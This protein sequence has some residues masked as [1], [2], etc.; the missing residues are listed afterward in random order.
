VERR[1]RPKPA[2]YLFHPLA[3][4]RAST[5]VPAAKLIVLLRDPITRAYSHWRRE[6]RDGNEP[7]R[8]FEEAIAAEAGRL[9]GEVERIV[10][11][12]RYYSYAHENFSY[13]TLGLYLD[14]LQRWFARY[15]RER[16]CIQ[17]TEQFLE[18][19]QAVYGTILRFLGLPPHAAATTA[20]E[21]HAYRST[22]QSADATDLILMRC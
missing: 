15:P 14:G 10:G 5:V 17:T 16:V 22:A 4:E 18:D 2:R 13:I 19:P 9:A 1:C 21:H 3:A 7:L 12:D 11:D 6:R 8:T 20:G